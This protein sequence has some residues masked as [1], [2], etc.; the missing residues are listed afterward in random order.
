MGVGVVM[1]VHGWVGGWVCGDGMLKSMGWGAM[2]C[3]A[4]SNHS[5]M[6]CIAVTGK[7]SRKCGPLGNEFKEI[8]IS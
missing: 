5:R 6:P 4:R 1:G 8:N 7:V 2:R 3:G